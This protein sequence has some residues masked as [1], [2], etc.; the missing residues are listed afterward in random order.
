[1][2]NH[3]RGQAGVIEFLVLILLL[4]FLLQQ[5]LVLAQRTKEGGILMLE[6]LMVERSADRLE[7]AVKELNFTGY[8]RKIIEIPERPFIKY[9]LALAKAKKGG[10]ILGAS[11]EDITFNK[12]LNILDARLYCPPGTYP[13][14]TFKVENWGNGVEVIC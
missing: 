6:R 4:L 10:V 2:G 11:F 5:S 3:S 8:G 1:M 12:D 7:F 13:N 14:I 9:Y